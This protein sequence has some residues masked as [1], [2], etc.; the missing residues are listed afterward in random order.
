MTYLASAFD[1]AECL[2]QGHTWFR[3]WSGIRS[4]QSP[5]LLLLSVNLKTVYLWTLHWLHLC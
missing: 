4:C 2:P 3:G 1:P 5:M